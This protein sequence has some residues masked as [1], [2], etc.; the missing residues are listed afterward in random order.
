VQARMFVHTLRLKDEND[1]N[2]FRKSSMK[3]LDIPSNPR[4]KYKKEWTSMGDW[5][6]TGSIAHQKRQFLSFEEARVFVRSLGL[7]ST[8]EFQS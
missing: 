4:E 8:D 6:G 5:L 3:P 2:K 7:K 1:W